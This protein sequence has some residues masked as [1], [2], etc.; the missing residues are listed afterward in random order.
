M[1]KAVVGDVPGGDGGGG[2][3]GGGDGGGG[4]GGGGDGGDEAL[5]VNR[6]VIVRD[7]EA[8]VPV[9]VIVDDP[10]GVEAAVVNVSIGE[11]SGLQDAGENEAVV[12]AGRPEAENETDC[13]LPEIRPAVI[14]LDADCPWTTLGF[15]PLESEKSKGGA[16]VTVKVNVVVRDREPPVPVTVI[17]DDPVGVNGV[18]V[19]VSVDEQPGLHDAGTNKGVVPAGSPE[20]EKEIDCV[21]PEI[22]IAVIVLDTNSPWTTV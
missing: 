16:A 5:T 14:V 9:T 21:V 10:V 8:P 15:P 4:D 2:D 7:R 22:R 6:K 18:V 17:V 3:G 12:P 19:R 11:Q 13:G 1:E 20:A